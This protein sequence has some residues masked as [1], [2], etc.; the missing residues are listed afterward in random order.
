MGRDFIEPATLSLRWMV[1][2]HSNLSH[3]ETM[4][5]AG[6]KQQR[7]TPLYQAA[8]M[9]RWPLGP[10]ASWKL[11]RTHFGEDSVVRQTVRPER[12]LQQGFSNCSGQA[13]MV[14][15][16]GERLSTSA[17]PLTTPRRNTTQE[18]SWPL[19]V[20]DIFSLKPKKPVRI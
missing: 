9:S 15:E 16:A 11:V 20:H 6:G 2:R 12:R 5:Q 3:I 18:T 10:V 4:L 13:T 14:A 7:G 8:A 1:S 19:Q 17:G